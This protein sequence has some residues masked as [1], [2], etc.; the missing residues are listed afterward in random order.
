M[1]AMRDDEA[2][3]LFM[4]MVAGIVVTFLVMRHKYRVERLRTIQKALDAG[5]IDELTRR[6]LLDGM[7]ADAQRSRQWIDAIFRNGARIARTLLFVAGWLT[8]TIGGVILVGMLIFDGSRYD[9]QGASIAV[10]IGFGVVTIPL[11]MR[12]LEGRRSVRN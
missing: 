5:H 11:A 3:A 2:F 12:E 8:F 7:A 4:I 6:T 10:A 1:F 9:I